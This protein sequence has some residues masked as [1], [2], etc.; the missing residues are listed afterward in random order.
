MRNEDM[1]PSLLKAF[2]DNQIALAGAIDEI[3]DWA[4]DAGHLALAAN[5]RRAIRPID[6]NLKMVILSLSLLDDL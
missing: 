6:D 1:L 2:N 3:A 4:E 5:V